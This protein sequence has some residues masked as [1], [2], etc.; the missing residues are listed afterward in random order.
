MHAIV[1]EGKKADE[2]DVETARFTSGIEALE[3]LLLQA[4][5]L[6]LQSSADWPPLAAEA[7]LQQRAAR[8]F[9]IGMRRAA[10]VYRQSGV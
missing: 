2:A 5:A 3:V 6:R 9:I 8:G 1:K 7:T 4:S 10:G